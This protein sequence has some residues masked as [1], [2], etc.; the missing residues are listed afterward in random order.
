MG[1]ISFSLDE[2][3]VAFFVRELP[4]ERFVET[5]AFKGD[6]L[7]IARRRFSACHSVEMSP[8]LYEQT[9]A[10]FAG[11]G[12][13]K[14]EQSDSPAFLR[15]HCK[16]FAAMP[17]LFW[18]DAHW[19]EASDTSGKESQSPLLDELTAI[20]SLQPDSV[21]LIDDAR[22]YLSAPP[23]PHNCAHW[24][25]FHSVLTALLKLSSQHRLTVFNDVIIF[26]PDR[27]APAMFEYARRNG[28]DWLAS[29]SLL[30]DFQT[31]EI[32]RR[33]RRFPSANFFRHLV[34][35]LTGPRNHAAS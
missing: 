3:L 13:I 22:L 23:P 28:V 20:H 11:I 32:E 18:L 4:L 25:D 31:R 34:R 5:G 7:E 35:R 12:N 30:H 6:S 19:C 16:E 27:I 2:N 15:R 21:I 17:A 9:L 26:Y 29:M 33:S 24:P 1:A 8:K 14:L 10:R